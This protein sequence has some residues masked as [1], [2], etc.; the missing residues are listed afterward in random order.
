MADTAAGSRRLVLSGEC[1][2]LFSLGSGDGSV[3][4]ASDSSSKGLGF[5]SRQE[6]RENF[7]L[8][9]HLS[10]LTVISVSVPPPCYRSST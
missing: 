9:G 2:I 3:V 5:E 8:Q 1:F 7:L 10:V 4:R 6:R